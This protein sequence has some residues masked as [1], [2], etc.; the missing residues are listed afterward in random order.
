MHHKA[1]SRAKDDSDFRH[2][3]GL[4]GDIGWAVSSRRY[5][6]IADG[7]E[8]DG[9]GASIAAST[10]GYSDWAKAGESGGGV[11]EEGGREGTVEEGTARRAGWDVV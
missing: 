2:G 11:A 4:G 3:R 8:C 9:D 7:A 6:A 5:C 10:A 1:D